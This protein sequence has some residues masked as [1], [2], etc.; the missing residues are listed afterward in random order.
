M[1]MRAFLVLFP[2]QHALRADSALARMNPLRSESGDAEKRNAP[3]S[4]LPDPEK[5][6]AARIELL[7]R[8]KAPDESPSQ[9]PQTFGDAFPVTLDR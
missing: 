9:Q 7:I 2:H 3:R 8:H 4:E 6:A 1:H 5:R